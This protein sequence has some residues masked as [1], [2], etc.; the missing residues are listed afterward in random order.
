MNQRNLRILD[1]MSRC[2]FE[3]YAC[4]GD[5]C[6][7]DGIIDSASRWGSGPHKPQKHRLST[8]YNGAD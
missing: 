3:I 1:Q 4:P 8:V 7:K 2:Q 5:S 6:S